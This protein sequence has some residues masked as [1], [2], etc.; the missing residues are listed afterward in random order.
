MTSD[1]IRKILAARARAAGSQQAAAVALGVSTTH[2]SDVIR[3]RQV[4]G[5]K[6][7]TALGLR[8]RDVEYEKVKVKA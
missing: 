6:L 3:G 4:P 7:L 8:R 2:F 1:D 5:P